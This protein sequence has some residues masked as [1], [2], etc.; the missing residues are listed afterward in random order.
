[1]RLLRQDFGEAVLKVGKSRRPGPFV[2]DDSLPV[3]VK[4]RRDARCPVR[5]R[6][7]PVGVVQNREED[8]IGL[9]NLFQPF[10]AGDLGD[11]YRQEDQFLIVFI[12]FPQL[13][14]VRQFFRTGLSGKAPDVEENGASLKPA[15][16]YGLSVDIGQGYIR[17]DVADFYTRRNES[18]RR[19]GCGRR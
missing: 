17:G 2:A 8:V 15:Q 13:F 6:G 12:L 18:G 9:E 1:M 10:G 3:D 7:R 4:S 16:G 5:I 14:H 19:P 11:A